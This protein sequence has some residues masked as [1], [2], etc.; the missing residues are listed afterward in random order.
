MCAACVSM[1]MFK[2][3]VHVSKPCRKLVS[4]LSDEKS[5]RFNF[6]FQSLTVGLVWQYIKDKIPGTNLAADLDSSPDR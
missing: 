6:F 5:G 3:R 4:E 1:E 2:L